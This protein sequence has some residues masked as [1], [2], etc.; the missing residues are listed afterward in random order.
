MESSRLMRIGL[1][2]LFRSLDP[3]CRPKLQR[4]RFMDL[5]RSIPIA[6]GLI[7][8]LTPLKTPFFAGT[9]P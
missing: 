2:V 8:A 6:V 3:R 5:R 7:S 1:I 4:T 9:I